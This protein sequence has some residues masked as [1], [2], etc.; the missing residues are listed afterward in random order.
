[1]KYPQCA[2]F[3]A[4]GLSFQMKVT[5]CSLASLLVSIAIARDAFVK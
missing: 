2:N 4:V 1:M 5:R 3:S